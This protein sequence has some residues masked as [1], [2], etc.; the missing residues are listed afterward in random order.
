MAKTSY[1]TL[2]QVKRMAGLVKHLR[3]QYVLAVGGAVL[4]FLTTLFIPSLII[5]LTWQ[6]LDGEKPPLTS[7]SI[8]VI[9]GLAR[10]LFRYMEHYFGHYVAFRTLYDFRCM[11]FSKL[12]QLAPARLDGQDSGQLLKMIGEDIEAMEVFFAH[13]IPPIATA[14][15]VTLLLTVYY[16][17]LSPWIALVALVTYALL[18]VVLPR[19]FAKGLTPLLAQQ[20]NSRKSYMSLFSDSLRGMKDLIQFG[21]SRARFKRLEEESLSVNARE[22]EV[23]E[24]NHVQTSSSFLVIGL[25]ML[26]V[27]YLAFRA[28]LDGDLSLEV[29]TRGLVIFATSFAPYLELSRLPLGFKR[30]MNAAGEVFELLDEAVLDKSGQDF[31]ESIDKIEVRDVSFAYDQR[32]QLIYDQLNL[33]FEKGK[34]IG[35]VGPSGSGKS[36]LM[37]LLMKW[38]QVTSGEIRL[39]NRVIADLDARQVQEKIAYIPQ[40]PQVFNQTIRE[41]LVLGRRDI[42]D[43]Q[44]LAAAEKCRIKDKILASRDG[45][46]TLINREQTIFSSGEL[47]RL[48]LTRAL[49]KEADCY[50]FDEPTSHLDSL[51]EAAFLQVMR[52]HCKGYVFL[53]SHRASTVASCDQLFTVT[54]RGLSLGQPV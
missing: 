4:G 48:E 15:L 42:T 10:G 24:A 45:L 20:S 18:A 9:L 39:N 30:A 5:S 46:D 14:S 1:S 38:Y 12:R 34:I 32:E 36:T 54:D 11:V 8:L 13:T 43:E 29:A 52:E 44:I 6:A 41:N 26:M 49:L 40:I 7:L 33:D 47:Q 28:V 25:A 16:L 50:I 37:K 3:F 51:N 2:G 22:Q 19:I 27:A 53:I 17:T 23:A 35:I 21:Q 31:K